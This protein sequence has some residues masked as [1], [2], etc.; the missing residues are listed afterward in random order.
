LREKLIIS[1]YLVAAVAANITVQYFG[2]VAMPF[3]AFVMIGLDL[4]SRDYLHEAWQGKHLGWKMLALIGVGSVLTYIVNQEAKRV[5]WASFIAFA[6]AGL[7][8]V[9]IYAL[10][11]GKARQLKVNGSNVVSALVDSVVFPAVAFGIFNI[12]IISVQYA[13]KVG[14]GWVWSMILERYVWNGNNH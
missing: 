8:D 6:S 7:T 9:V 10:L 1:G 2:P 12:K 11:K 5:A 14:G 13:A 4:T 3:I